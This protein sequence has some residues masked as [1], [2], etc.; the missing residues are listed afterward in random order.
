[1]VDNVAADCGYLIRDLLRLG[2]STRVAHKGECSRNCFGPSPCKTKTQIDAE[3]CEKHL[4]WVSVCW[5]ACMLLG[6]TATSAKRQTA[7]IRFA[8]SALTEITNYNQLDVF[9][10]KAKDDSGHPTPSPF[11]TAMVTSAP[12]NGALLPVRRQM[13][14]E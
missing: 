12:R 14:R 3:R 13:H 10:C 6:A 8:V 4:E 2:P 1:M 7:S 9:L 5:Q 11:D